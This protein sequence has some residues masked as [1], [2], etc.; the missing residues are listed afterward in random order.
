MAGGDTMLTSLLACGR[1]ISPVAA[2]FR[3]DLGVTFLLSH[4]GAG[5]GV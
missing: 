4:S 3:Y 5:A 2:E 1:S